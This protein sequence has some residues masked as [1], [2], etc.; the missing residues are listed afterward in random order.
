MPNELPIDQTPDAFETQLKPLWLQAQKGDTQAYKLALSMMAARLRRFFTH[1]LQSLPSEVEDLVQETLIALHNK[2]GT[3]DVNYP[4]SA[5]LFA[6]ARHKLVD[7]HRRRGRTESLHDS[8]DD[9]DEAV[10]AIEPKEQSASRDI[11]HLLSRLPKAQREAIEMTKLQGLS[12]DEAALQSGHSVAAIKVQVHRGMKQ[13]A[14]QI[15]SA[16]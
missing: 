13:L 5:W 2:R 4:V 16:G 11:A 12:M 7:L 1:K 8:L 9:V 6:I 10:L 14:A 15:R 3:Y